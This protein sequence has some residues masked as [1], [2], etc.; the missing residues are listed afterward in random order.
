MCHHE[1]DTRA[2]QARPRGRLMCLLIRADGLPLRRDVC[3]YCGVPAGLHWH[4]A[5]STGSKGIW[6]KTSS[7]HS[8]SWAWIGK[9]TD[10]Q[11]Q[12]LLSMFA[13][14]YIY[15]YLDGACAHTHKHTH[16]NMQTYTQKPVEKWVQSGPWGACPP[17]CWVRPVGAPTLAASFTVGCLG[18]VVLETIRLGVVW[19]PLRP[20]PSDRP[21][22]ECFSGP[23][24]SS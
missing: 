15:I 2:C 8:G 20:C 22:T 12:I 17:P 16:I 7:S 21:Q 13:D 4:P 11:T 3:S 23:G 14:I 10:A 6:W 18:D 9:H 5:K 24:I 1:Q 19:R